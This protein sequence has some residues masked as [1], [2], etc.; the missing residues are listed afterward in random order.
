MYLH[1][2]KRCKVTNPAVVIKAHG[3]G[4]GS[5]TGNDRPITN[6]KPKS[7]PKDKVKKST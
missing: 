4:G 2:H 6:P 3:A 1:N 7:I 5:N